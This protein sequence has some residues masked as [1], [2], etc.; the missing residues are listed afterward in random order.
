MFGPPIFPNLS[1]FPSGWRVL[2]VRSPDTLY[3]VTGP[4]IQNK[5]GLCCLVAR[6]CRLTLS[7]TKSVVLTVLPTIR[8]SESRSIK[9]QWLTLAPPVI[10]HF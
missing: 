8:F 7:A 9:E 2:L 4:V 5:G 6:G 3:S 10:I 1:S